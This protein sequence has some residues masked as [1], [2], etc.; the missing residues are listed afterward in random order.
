MLALVLLCA[1]A[2]CAAEDE[3]APPP[4]NGTPWRAES[5]QTPLPPVPEFEPRLDAAAP[6][7]AV[8]DYDRPAPAAQPD[9]NVDVDLTA[10]SSTM[11]YAEV[12]NIMMQ[13]DSY[14]GKRIKM[15]GAYNSQ[16]LA[17][18]DAQVHFVVIADATACCAQGL[19]FRLSADPAPVYPD[20]YPAANTY[21]EVT[22]TFGIYEIGDLEYYYVDANKMNVI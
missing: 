7:P 17:E 15:G 2:G 20:D 8:Y 6:P 18:E 21:V 4:V 16:Y 10:L 11:V 12:F 3:N 14:V 22:G 1:V 13:P 5:S 9:P 19:E